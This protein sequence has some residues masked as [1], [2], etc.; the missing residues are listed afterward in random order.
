MYQKRHVMIPHM[1]KPAVPA[2][3]S[4]S[5]SGT[6][7]AFTD[8]TPRGWRI[9]GFL[10]ALV[11]GILLLAACGVSASTVVNDQAN[12]GQP[13]GSGE[14]R[15]NVVATNSLLADLVGQVGGNL[16][17][18]T[19]L[20]PPGV[21]VHA[22][23]LKPSNNL[24]IGRAD[25]LVSNGGGLDDF[26][27]PVLRNSARPEAKWIIIADGLEPSALLDNGDPHFWLDPGLALDYVKQ[28]QDGLVEV[29][30]KHEFD[31]TAHA[32]TYAGQISALD[33]EIE[34]LLGRVATERRHLVTYH[35]A[36]GHLARRYNWEATALVPDDGWDVAPRT[37]ANLVMRIKRDGLPSVFVE[38]QFQQGLLT[39]TAREAGIRVGV[40]YSLPGSGA[41]TYLDM[42]RYN[43]E[44]IVRELR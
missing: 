39:R 36:F 28:I 40:V 19:A 9:G 37:L 7:F 5:D 13:L 14:G 20:V 17:E 8:W 22:F 11:T 24:A 43:A 31:Y 42:M 35:D 4:G 3:S 23:Q 16:V 29:D 10:A 38:P 27:N 26:L 18:V 34:K 41:P 2:M 30:P 15:I 32:E 21:D 6:Q 25:L 44:S 1:R 33:Q 12:S